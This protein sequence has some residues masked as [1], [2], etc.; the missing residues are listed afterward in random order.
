MTEDTARPQDAGRSHKR[1][2][3]PSAETSTLLAAYQEAMRTELRATLTEIEGVDPPPSLEL[4]DEPPG[5]VR[6]KLEVRVRLWDLAIKLGRELGTEVDPAGG[7]DAADGSPPVAR[8]RR[9][10]PDFGGA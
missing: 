6:P 7:A 9:R 1:R 5:K 3:R 8:R 10:R 4:T 2:G